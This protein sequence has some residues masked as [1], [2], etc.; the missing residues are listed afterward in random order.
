MERVNHIYTHNV[1]FQ[2]GGFTFKN[3][4]KY[5]GF[6]L[7]SIDSK[8]LNYIERKC[9]EIPNQEETNQLWEEFQKG[10]FNLV[11]VFCG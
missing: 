11:K 4:E 5:K 2:I 10:N 3:T 9:A 6:K 7:P 1:Q 8:F